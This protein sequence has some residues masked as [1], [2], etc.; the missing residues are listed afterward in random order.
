MTLGRKPVDHNA[1][2]GRGSSAPGSYGHS[3]EGKINDLAKALG[4]PSKDL[5]SAIAMAVRQYVPPASLSSVASKEI[6][7]AVEALLKETPTDDS[8]DMR[9]RATDAETTPNVVEEVVTGF[10]KFVGMDE[11]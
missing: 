9:S 7:P 1:G 3:V 2:S 4:M 5:A 8:S 11:P 10:N 6:G